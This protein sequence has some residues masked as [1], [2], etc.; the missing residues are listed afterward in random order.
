MRKIL[1]LVVAALLC[2]LAVK[3]AVPVDKKYLAGAVPVVSG[4]VLYEKIYEVPGKTAGE[5]LE[6]VRGY[7]EA[8]LVSGPD[9]GPQARLTEVN[10]EDGI[11]AASIQ[12]TMWFLRKPMRSDFCQFYYQI[13]F[14]V[15]DGA[16][17]VMLR[18]LRYTYELTDRPEDALTVRA[19]E[20]ITDKEAL[21]KNGTKMKKMNGKFRKATVD[22][23]D[24]IFQNI[25]KALGAKTMNKTIVVEEY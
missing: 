25:G 15:K 18:G 16:V 20:W 17:D 23:K 9:H 6:L 10:A 19:E 2:G 11:V 5:L 22:R 1:T 12:E 3:A 4:Q 21:S 24:A 7:A 8:E 13:V 14:Q